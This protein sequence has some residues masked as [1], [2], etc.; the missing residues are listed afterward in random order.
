MFD[1]ASTYIHLNFSASAVRAAVSF[2][3]CKNVAVFLPQPA[4]SWFIS[5]SVGIKGIF[6]STL[7]FGGS[8]V[9]LCRLEKLF[10]DYDEHAF[11][12]VGPAVRS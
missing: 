1:F 8:Q 12:V 6:R 7:V 10:V 2:S 9:R 5:S 3:T 11:V 4:T